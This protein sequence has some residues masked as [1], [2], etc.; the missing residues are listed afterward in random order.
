VGAAKIARK[1]LGLD[2]GGPNVGDPVEEENPFLRDA[3][4]DHAGPPADY[5][6]G[7]ARRPFGATVGRV[8]IYTALLVLIASGFNQVVVK[9]FLANTASAV[10]VAT[11]GV[12]PEVARAVAGRFT[13]E[14]L[15]YNPA[16]PSAGLAAM[17]ASMVSAGDPSQFAFTGSGW[18][19]PELVIPSRVTTVDSSM[20]IVTVQA[21]V[22]LGRPGQ[23]STPPPAAVTV[24]PLPGHPGNDAPLP[25]GYQVV[26]SQWLDLQIPV[27]LAN[28]TTLVAQGGPVFGIESGTIPAAG[29]EDS[30]TTSTTKE[31][32][33]ALFA[34]YAGPSQTGMDYLTTPGSQ[35][36]T[37]AGAVTLTGV[38][39]WKLRT[40]VDGHRVG[41][42]RVGWSFQPSLDLATM[43]TYDVSTTSSDNRWFATAI[44]PHTINN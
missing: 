32:A 14:Y 31:W 13:A 4:Q 7:K 1:V 17:S 21:K 43:Q 36:T 27:A 5:E 42:A 41:T 37:L 33:A 29:D 11:V 18:M 12:D 9:P 10:P 34:A 30:T 26:G 8:V 38:Q 2:R 44:A 6:V 25:A 28:G 22:S 39:S 15:T 20:V 24:S 16:A 35:I 3:P 19:A 23:A 40:V